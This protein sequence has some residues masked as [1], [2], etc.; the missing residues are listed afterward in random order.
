MTADPSVQKRKADLLDDAAVLLATIAELGASDRDPFTDENV[1]ARAV[2]IGLLDA[3]HLRGNK[4]GCGRI[5]TRMIGGACLAFDPLR[6]QAIPETERVAQVMGR[7]LI[8]IE[9][10][11]ATR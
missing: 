10:K 9:P 5:V 3:P 11:H 6:R 4:A 7:P 1:L 2:E 8:A